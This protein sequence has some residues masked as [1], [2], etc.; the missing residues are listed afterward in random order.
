[1]IT[2][3]FPFRRARGQRCPLIASGLLLLVGSLGGLSTHAQ[4]V[5]GVTW[6]VSTQ[7]LV[8]GASPQSIAVG[9]FNGDGKADIA[10]AQAGSIGIFLGNG[11]GTFKAADVA[12]DGMTISVPLTAPLAIA[13]GAFQTG[14]PVGLVVVSAS[15][16]L[17][18]IHI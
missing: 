3:G 10:V 5:P 13:A 1:M 14:K 4:T 8:T 2:R 7:K 6:T 9:D 12:N 18:L 15:Y 11:D 17:S 16:N